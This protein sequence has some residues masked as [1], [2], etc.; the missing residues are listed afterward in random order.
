ME[1]I[2]ITLEDWKMDAGACFGVIPKSLW[3]KVYPDQTDN[4]LHITNRSLLIKQSDRLILIDTGYGSK[5]PDKYYQYK[6]LFN[7]KGIE[8][9]LQ[10]NNIE[11]KDIT[12]VL[13]THLHDDHVGGASKRVGK[14]IVDLFPNATYWVSA[15]QWLWATHPNKRESAAYFSE[16]HTVLENSGRLNK[17]TKSGEYIPGIEFRIY[18]GHTEGQIIPMINYNG[19]KVVYTADFIPSSAHIPLVYI[20]AVDI[21]PLEVLEEKEAFLEEASGNGYILFFEHDYYYET[22]KIEKTERGYKAIHQNTLKGN[23]IE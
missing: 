6:Y 16:N 23:T 8:V 17:V 10:E 7:Q 11:C 9:A 3:S 4:L 18:N 1:L 5:Q 22:C 19:K 20:A 14:E 21:K 2:P 12:D 13:L 15:A